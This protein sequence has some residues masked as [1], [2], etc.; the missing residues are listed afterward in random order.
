MNGYSTRDYSE[1][2]SQKRWD[3]GEVPKN[4]QDVSAQ[5]NG[6][7]SPNERTVLKK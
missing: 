4:K 3:M 5:E 7:W 1:N 6:K 2:V